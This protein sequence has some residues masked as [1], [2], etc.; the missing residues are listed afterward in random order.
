MIYTKFLISLFLISLFQISGFESRAQVR[1]STVEAEQQRRAKYNF[2]P[3]ED[4]FEN[5]MANRLEE[6]RNK[7]IPFGTGEVGDPDEIA[8]VVHV[9]HNDGDAYGEGTNITDEQ[10]ISQIEVLNEDYQRKNA[11]TIKTQDEFLNIT[12][13]L[14]LK[15][16]LARQDINGDPTTGIVRVQGEKTS[17]NITISDRELL[18]S[19][20]QWDPNLY[21]NI[22]VVNLSGSYIGLAQFP[23]YNLPGLEDEDNKDNEATDGAV[24]D[25]HA[26]GSEDKVPGIDVLSSYNLGRTTTHEIAHF[27]GLKHVWGDDTSIQGCSKDDYVDDTPNSNKDYSGLCQDTPQAS[28]GN[29][30]MFENFLYY[31]N[32]ACMNSFTDGQVARME[33]I[34]DDAP[35]RAS[36]LNSIGTEYPGDLFFDLAIE[37]ITS[38]GMVICDGELIPVVRIKNN[39]TIPVVN[40]DIKY[41]LNGN[42]QLYTYED[43]T[44][45][46]GE[47]IE[48]ALAASQE[49]NGNYKLD[50]ELE[51][52]PD[53]VNSTNNQADH[54]FAIDN[55]QDFIPLREQF[56][57]TDIDMTN[58]I[59]INE[60]DEIGWV[61]SNAPNYYDENSSASIYFYNYEEMNEQDWLISPALDF[62][63]AQEAS[64]T[65]NTSYAK[66]QNFNDQLRIVVSKDCG[67]SFS[68]TLKIFNADDLAVTD[69]EDFWKP[70]DQSEWK[71]H[72]VDLSMYA[73]ESDIRLAFLTVNGYGNNLYL[74]D[75]EFYATAEEYLVKTARS[76]F[77]VYPNPTSDHEVKL[78]FNTNY[79]QEVIVYIYDSMG[80]IVTN[81]VFQNTLNQTYYYDM[82]GY[83]SGVY[84]LHALGEDFARV[85]RLVISR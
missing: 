83:R 21:L 63:T 46:S 19:Y 66:N 45:F 31:T 68:E 32:D 60:D 64:L 81:D 44:V 2:L 57:V 14:N 85:K 70:V 34:L 12:G 5:W 67:N 72:V 71:S 22:W 8:V 49:E 73:G 51:N 28:C 74:D 37:S 33:I 27:F 10:I 4:E 79:R 30:D 6:R 39:G 38:P 7:L 80:K 13:C 3:S 69:H 23:D 61:I 75:I 54:V 35:R 29:N 9:I 41:S 55:Q 48:V 53:D 42:S 43:D 50:V 52:I 36:L 78:T 77:I 26:F 82:T 47:I 15:F 20:S 76:S 25:Y 11:D 58:W 40:F 56:D 24:I 16:V 65:F 1:C 84:F 59:E 18:S 62:S 17:Y